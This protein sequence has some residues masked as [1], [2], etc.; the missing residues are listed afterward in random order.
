MMPSIRR[1]RE[2]SDTCDAASSLG[3]IIAIIADMI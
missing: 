3:A 2:I 1:G